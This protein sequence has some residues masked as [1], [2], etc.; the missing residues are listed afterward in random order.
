MEN[1]RGG[2]PLLER[3]ARLLSA[4]HRRLLGSPLRRRSGLGLPGVRILDPGLGTGHSHLRGA[5][6][7][8]VGPR[9]RLVLPLLPPR[10]VPGERRAV[11]RGRYATRPPLHPRRLHHGPSHPFL[12]QGPNGETTMNVSLS[13]SRRRTPESTS[14]TRRPTT[15][16][17]SVQLDSDPTPTP[18]PSLRLRP[19]RARQRRRLNQ[20]PV[21]SRLAPPTA[22]GLVTPTD[23]ILILHSPLEFTSS[24]C[25][26]THRAADC[27]GT[28]L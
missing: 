8:P 26:A 25:A 1:G 4:G 5:A 12:V 28:V 23:A 14:L 22:D 17:P 10:R 11:H 16:T 9:G 19:P 20:S 24:D 13:G 3:R 7:R 18:T 21:S 6:V 15:T 27:D 2:L